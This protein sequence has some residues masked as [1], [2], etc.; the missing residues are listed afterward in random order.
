M[1]SRCWSRI[2]CSFHKRALFYYTRK[3]Y[4]CNK[5]FH[6]S[7]NEIA[8]LGHACIFIILCFSNKA[9]SAPLNG[10]YSMWTVACNCESFKGSFRAHCSLYTQLQTADHMFFFLGWLFISILGCNPYPTPTRT[11]WDVRQR[12]KKRHHMQIC[13]QLSLAYRVL[14]VS[15]G[16]TAESVCFLG[17]G[18]RMKMTAG[19]RNILHDTYN[20]PT[21]PFRKKKNPQGYVKEMFLSWKPDSI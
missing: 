18:G 4:I 1:W 20:P 12:N 8:Q 19:W 14:S 7:L 16:C 2:G 11:D 9:A 15:C 10:T 5:Y 3:K 21:P 6:F 13:F 17:I